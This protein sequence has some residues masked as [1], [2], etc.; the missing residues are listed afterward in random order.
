MCLSNRLG[1]LNCL[2]HDGHWR[3]GAKEGGGETPSSSSSLLLVD[4]ALLLL[5][6][7][8]DKVAKLVSET[9]AGKARPNNIAGPEHNNI[10]PRQSLSQW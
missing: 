9:P 10:P 4:L 8:D 5:L 6:Y 2:G 3:V 7:V 1:T